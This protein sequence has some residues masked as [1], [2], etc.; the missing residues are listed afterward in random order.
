MTKPSKKSTLKKLKST[1][2]ANRSGVRRLRTPL[3]QDKLVELETGW[4]DRFYV[5]PPLVP[6]PQ[7]LPHLRSAVPQTKLNLINRVQDDVIYKLS[8]SDR[9]DVPRQSETKKY[10]SKPKMSRKVA[11]DIRLIPL[12]VSLHHTPFHVSGRT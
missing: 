8:Q 9:N 4:N 6:R 5:Q 11:A 3:S 1:K 10:L 7:H 2:P 12:E